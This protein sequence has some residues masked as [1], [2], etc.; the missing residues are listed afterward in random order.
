MRRAR[1]S[2]ERKPVA[3]NGSRAPGSLLIARHD[4]RLA[5]INSSTRVGQPFGRGERSQFCHST[6]SLGHNPGARPITRRSAAKCA[7][8]I[9][10]RPSDWAT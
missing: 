1:L 6:G 4:V 2:L 9:K 7:L 8:T 10:G 5:G 3:S